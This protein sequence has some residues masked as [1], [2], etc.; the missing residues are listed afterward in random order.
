[1][2]EIPSNYSHGG[3]GIGRGAGSPHLADVLRDIAD[4]LAGLKTVAIAEADADGT[5]GAPEAAL[6]NEMKAALNTLNA[7]VI[8]TTKGA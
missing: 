3:A 2:A 7:Y 1:M 5:Y 8:K 6:I 4:D